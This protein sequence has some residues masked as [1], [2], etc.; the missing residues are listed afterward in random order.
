MLT[1][2]P[3]RGPMGVR[4]RRVHLLFAEL[5]AE[6]GPERCGIGLLGGQCLSLADYVTVTAPTGEAVAAGCC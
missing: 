5:L 3:T 6:A 2:F 1:R 4:R